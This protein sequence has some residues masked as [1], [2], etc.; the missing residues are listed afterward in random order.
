[1]ELSQENSTD[2]LQD[3][4]PAA[5]IFEFNILAHL[6]KIIISSSSLESRVKSSETAP[7]NGKGFN[8]MHKSHVFSHLSALQVD[9]FLF[10]LH[11]THIFLHQSHL[12]CS[13]KQVEKEQGGSS[14]MHGNENHLQSSILLTPTL[15]QA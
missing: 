1:M 3:I 15:I 4:P 9:T 10:H 2:F 14:G 12:I 6:I 5:I 7:T 8:R 13:I 11:P